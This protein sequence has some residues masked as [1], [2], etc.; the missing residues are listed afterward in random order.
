MSIRRPRFQRASSKATVQLTP[1]DIEILRHIARHRFLR[2]SHI[3]SLVEG[4][5]QQLLRRLGLLYHHGY[6]ERPRCQIDYYHAGGSRHMA[7]GLAKRGV[8]T[9]RRFD[10]ASSHRTLCGFSA[11]TVKRLFLDHALS[12]SDVMVAVEL[13]CR[14]HG[15]KLLTEAELVSPD[16]N[17]PR[18]YLFR[19]HISLANGEKV[20]VIPDNAFALEWVDENN[21][22]QRANYLLE[23]DRGNMP[24][25]RQGFQQSSIQRKLL[26]YEATWTHDLHRTRFGFNR[27][28]VLFV[29]TTPERAEN[30]A[31]AARQ[32]ERGHGLFLFTDLQVLLE[33]D[34]LLT[35]PWRTTQNAV[36]TT[37]LE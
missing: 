16:K 19:W 36:H 6:V 28:R 33:A 12:V 15:V 22:T 5:R 11:G 13:T 4:S 24:M 10:G 3:T 27:F 8:A 20:G 35:H 34:Y 26:A 25:T 21:Q 14:Q 7:Y 23:V 31:E 18:R 1:R 29:T 32:L 2:S 17:P 30:L 37:L 9:L